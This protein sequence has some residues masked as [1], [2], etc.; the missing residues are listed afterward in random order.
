M[1]LVTLE[2]LKVALAIKS[3]STTDDDML[4]QY[5][6]SA[7]ALIQSYLKIY[8]LESHTVTS[9]YYRGTNTRYIRLRDRPVI[10]VTSVYMDGTGYFGQGSDPFPAATLLTAGTHYALELDHPA[11]YSRSGLVRRIDGVWPAQVLRRRGELAPYT[12]LA[13]G[14]IKVT[15]VAGFATIPA[16]LKQVVYMMVAQMRHGGFAGGP[17]SQEGLEGY[18]VSLADPG[19]LSES[20]KGLLAPYKGLALAT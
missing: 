9:E 11:G 6:T 16:D 1:A 5:I 14:N 7:Q 12:D 2:E 17:L 15:Y 18:S 10:S 8:N 3:S 20:I 13:A 19:L 4:Y